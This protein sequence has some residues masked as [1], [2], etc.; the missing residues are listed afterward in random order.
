MGI[1]RKSRLSDYKQDRLI[2]HFMSGSTALTTAKLCGV[3]L[4]PVQVRSPAPFLLT[5]NRRGRFFVDTASLWRAISRK[6]EPER[7][8][9]C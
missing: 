9:F 5:S 6:L 1:V 2:E 3:N 8:I 7:P 4:V